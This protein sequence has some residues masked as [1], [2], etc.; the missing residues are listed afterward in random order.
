[1]SE[2]GKVIEDAESE[3]MG[4]RF[5]DVAHHVDLKFLGQLHFPP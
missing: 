5:E 3:K 4:K 2:V 1:M